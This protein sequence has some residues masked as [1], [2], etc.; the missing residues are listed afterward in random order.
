MREVEIR[1]LTYDIRRTTYFDR[2]LHTSVYT[3]HFSICL[4]IAIRVLCWGMFLEAGRDSCE[5]EILKVDVEG[6][7]VVDMLS[8]DKCKR[9]C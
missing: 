1:H 9:L 6:A 2:V 3:C 7:S 4:C 5:V 8:F